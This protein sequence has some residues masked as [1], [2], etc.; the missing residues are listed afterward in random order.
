MAFVPTMPVRDRQRLLA[1]VFAL[2]PD[3]YVVPDCGSVIAASRRLLVI[4]PGPAAAEGHGWRPGLC[5]RS[6]HGCVQVDGAHALAEPASRLSARV[7][8][9]DAFEKI[10]Y[11]CLAVVALAWLA[12][13]LI[14]V[15]AATPLSWIGLVGLIG[16]GILFVKVLKERLTSAEDDHYDE[17]V[18]R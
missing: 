18:D 11:L 9:M 8:S 2:R 15:V 12:A 7:V 4:A 13:I 16:I 6:R 17:T 1:Q 10:G 14:G 3:P 5:N